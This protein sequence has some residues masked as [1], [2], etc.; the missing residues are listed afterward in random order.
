MRCTFMSIS[1]AITFSRMSVD[2][3]DYKPTLVQV[4]AWFLHTKS[5][6]LNQCW[7]RFLTPYDSRV[8]GGAGYLNIFMNDQ[9]RQKKGRQYPFEYYKTVPY[10]FQKTGCLV[11]DNS[12]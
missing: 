10:V 7:P 8:G 2:P 3:T 6:C 12:C 1:N 9:T 4:M 5:H 11:G